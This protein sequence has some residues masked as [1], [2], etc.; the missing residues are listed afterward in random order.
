MVCKELTVHADCA[1]A[2]WLDVILRLFGLFKIWILGLLSPLMEP[3]WVKVFHKV[4]MSWAVFVSDPESPGLVLGFWKPAPLSC[5]ALLLPNPTPSSKVMTVVCQES[6]F[7][8]PTLWLF[9]AWRQHCSK[10]CTVSHGVVQTGMSKQGSVTVHW[11]VSL[12]REAELQ[13]C[14]TQCRELWKGCSAGSQVLC[15]YLRSACCYTV[16]CCARR[17]P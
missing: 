3:S 14:Q 11:T 12:D 8:D 4:L 16:S 2:V 9:C 17:T 7:L 10:T 6:A 15:V 13:N 5:R 1:L